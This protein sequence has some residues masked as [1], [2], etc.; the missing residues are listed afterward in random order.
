MTIIRAVLSIAVAALLLSPVCAGAHAFLD[1]SDPA[2]GSTVPTS[3][4]VIHL[5]FT[6]QLEPA[7]SSVTVTDK[8]GAPV[9]DGPAQIDSGNKFELDVKLKTLDVGT[10]K[11]Q[12]HVLSV[13]THRTQGDY[14]FHVGKG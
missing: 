10:Y 11:V 4:A 2:V 5:W 14:S 6:Q 12:W 8:S 9:N 7:F 3:P 1:H 13:D